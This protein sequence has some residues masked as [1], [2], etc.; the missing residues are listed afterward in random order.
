[1]GAV[2]APV[3]YFVPE[4]R[5]HQYG[6]MVTLGI[7]VLT[8]LALLIWLLAFSRAPRAAKWVGLALALSPLGLYRLHGFTG[9]WIPI[10]EPRFWGKTKPFH[11]VNAMADAGKTRPDFAQFLGP[12]RNGKLDQPEL[13]PDWAAH[14]PQIVWRRDIGTGWSGFVVADNK[15]V[16]QEERDGKEWVVCQELST[17]N[18]I[19]RMENGGH[20]SESMAGEGPRATPTIAS[21]RVFA[22]GSTG[23]LNCFQ[24]AD[25]KQLWSRDLKADAGVPPPLYGFSSSPLVVGTK[26]VVSA[27][28]QPDKSLLAY[29]IADGNPAWAAGNARTSYSSPFLRTVLGQ[30]Q[31][32]MLNADV[33]T[34]HDPSNG[35]VLWEYP[36]ASGRPNVAQPLVLNERQVFVSSGYAYGA[37]LISVEPDGKGAYSASRLWKSP[38]FQAKFS[39]PVERGGF[40][41]GVS[42]GD[43]ACL[44]LKDGSRRWKGARYGHGQC[45][46]VGDLFLQMAEDPGVLVLLRPTPEAPNELGRFPV[47]EQKTW[48]P[49]ALAG[50]LLLAR[51]D[52]EAACIRL[53]VK[54]APKGK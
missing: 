7:V 9:D 49:I 17:G 52:R 45:L 20:F 30:D 50:D 11:V 22:L 5:H 13:D 12:N 34:A 31:I 4:W 42:D 35:K 36:W 24:L 43:F 44:D 19:W 39:N 47:F 28:G 23:G 51:N 40:V 41:Y 53:P 25:G 29:E 54:A 8:G 18:E 46:L 48:N 2:A 26:V 27:G 16:T 32:L 10:F 15:A 33:V 21:G 38:R 37:E 6:V 1:M 3:C 14:P